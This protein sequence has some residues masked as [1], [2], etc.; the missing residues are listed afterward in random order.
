MGRIHGG[1][2]ELITIDCSVRVGKKGRTLGKEGM[3]KRWTESNPTMQTITFSALWVRMHTT[4]HR[5][6]GWTL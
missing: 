2:Q 3:G 6:A 1:E 4:E 5:A